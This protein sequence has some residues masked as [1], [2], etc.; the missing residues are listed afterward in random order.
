MSVLLL[1]RRMRT[2][3][4]KNLNF[5]LLV[6]LCLVFKDS[7]KGEKMKRAQATY[8]TK[9]VE[10][11]GWLDEELWKFAPAAKNFQM[12]YPVDEGEVSGS[13]EVWVAY[14]D[15]NLYIAAKCFNASPVENYVVQSL[16][17][18]FSFP[19]NDAFAVFLDPY[20]DQ[21]N[22][23]SFGVSPYGVQREGLLVEGGRFGVTTSWDQ[24]YYAETRRSADFW[25]LEMA[26]PFKSFRYDMNAD[27]WGINFARNNLHA[28]EQ[29]TWSYVPKGYN[30][31]NMAFNGK[32]DFP[33]GKLPKAIPNI[34]AI[35]YFTIGFGDDY[36]A[37]T[38][39]SLM[40]VG[41]DAKIAL[42]S[43]LNLDLTVNPDFSQVEI[44]R[45]VTN[46]T[47]FSIALPERRQFFLENSDLFATLGR[48]DV[49]PFFSRRIGLASG[50]IIPILYGARLSG[51]LNENWRLGL[52]N[53]HTGDSE[54][55]GID[56]QNYS[57]A[58]LQRKLFSRSSFSFY[59][60]TRSA[61]ED[62]DRLDDFNHILGGDF[63]FRSADGKVNV[64]TFIQSAFR[65][66]DE[67]DNSTYSA[68]AG[69][70]SRKW[71]FSADGLYVGEGF[72]A[73][74]GFVPRLAN[75]D[76]LIGST[77]Y[78]SYYEF[79]ASARRWLY[80]GP[81]AIFRHGPQI[82]WTNFYD[83]D[84]FN[85]Q[86]ILNARYTIALKS[87][88]TFNINYRFN[89]ENL[90]YYTALIG[91]SF[92]PLPIGNYKYQF[93]SADYISDRRKRLW[94]SASVN[95]GEF[96]NG[97]R[98]GFQAELNY[99]IQPVTQL[100]LNFRTD[101]IQ[102]PNQY[103]SRRL[104]LIGADAGFSFTRDVNWTTFIQYNTQSD[105]FN[106]NS[107]MQYRFRPM[108][109]LFLVY[110][111]NYDGNFEGKSRALIL[112]LQWWLGL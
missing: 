82:S 72:R 67:E 52:M 77:F 106:I 105:N 44:D 27:S 30:V 95:A 54:E 49:R 98:N 62:F 63:I 103:G 33:D 59:G 23:F 29:S 85:V 4:Y 6:L 43:A 80:N 22:G 18:D 55:A 38:R 92:E 2:I 24:A 17:R 78:E 66:E 60:M 111:D 35:P 83:T 102:F 90:K 84:F 51:K 108:S 71:E 57:V 12:N 16:K 74:T 110:T 96:Y 32:L 107:R 11:D 41:G 94:Y 89:D 69:Y 39:E 101:N 28:N 7:V 26:I 91:G 75:F 46:L 65:D 40:N 45:Q 37:D 87:R 48:S 73:E 5:V 25:T 61:F 70:V 47:R 8:T 86:G 31:A 53:L 34:V 88:A 97:N 58:V 100:A 21:Y 112:K 9:T 104:Y 10:V 19:V 76:A 68:E 3:G 81:A 20:N 36:V 99:R 15:E 1:V 64:K 50:R 42:T 56:A 79:G 93:F 109:D 14:D 13:T